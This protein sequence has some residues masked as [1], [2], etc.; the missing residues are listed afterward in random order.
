MPLML[1]CDAFLVRVV[2]S[3]GH[4]ASEDHSPLVTL[5]I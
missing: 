5:A 3:E 4:A 2:E 1:A